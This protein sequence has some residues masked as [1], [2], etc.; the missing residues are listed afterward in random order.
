MWRPL[1]KLIT[2]WVCVSILLDMSL[3]YW[4]TKDWLSMICL[5][6]PSQVR[7]FEKC[8]FGLIV[9]FL[10]C[11]C[12]VWGFSLMVTIPFKIMAVFLYVH[13]VWNLRLLGMITKCQEILKCDQ[14]NLRGKCD[15]GILGRYGGWKVNT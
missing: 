8:S 9:P 3:E 15:W 4:C 2:L 1:S 12:R 5:F 6:G 13:F 7:I 14:F 11:Q 10:L